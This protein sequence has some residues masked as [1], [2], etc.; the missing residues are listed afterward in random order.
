MTQS[1]AG[2]GR[3]S[4]WSP[5]RAV[6]IL[7]C[8]SI[9]LE[10]A[11]ACALA[12]HATTAIRPTPGEASGI[13]RRALSDLDAEVRAGRL[14]AEQRDRAATLL[15]FTGDINEVTAAQLVIESTLEAIPVK[16]ALLEQAERLIWKDTVLVANGSPLFLR[17]VAARL[18]RPERFL[19]ANLFAPKVLSGYCEICPL[20]QTSPLITEAVLAF[21][22]GVGKATILVRNQPSRILGRLLVPHLIRTI[23]DVGSRRLLFSKLPPMRL[24]DGAPGGLLALADRMGLDVLLAAAISLEHELQDEHFHPPELLRRLV[25]MNQL[26]RK[27]GAGFFIHTGRFPIENPIVTRYIAP[28]LAA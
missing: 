17:A 4:Q 19:G 21:F 2:D 11:A 6:A 25:A 24:A 27:T 18:L 12:G 16:Q 9:G 14:E 15:R 23:E 7:G 10:L 8:G 28:F 5:F 3:P 26:G 22:R 1:A 13:E 20:P